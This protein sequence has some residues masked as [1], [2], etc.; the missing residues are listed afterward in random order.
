MKKTTTV[1]TL[2]LT[3]IAALSTGI[4]VAYARE[5]A[6]TKLAKSQKIEAPASGTTK[7]FGDWG[8]SCNDNPQ[9]Q[10][11]CKLAQELRQKSD[12]ARISMLEVKPEGQSKAAAGLTLP[13]GLDIRQGVSLQVDSGQIVRGINFSTCFQQ[14]C[15]VPMNFDAGTL[16]TL[17]NGKVLKITGKVLN[18]NN[19]TLNI[20]LQGFG[21][22]YDFMS[23]LTNTK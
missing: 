17:K 10:K 12:N 21:D 20:P 2:I 1:A 15:L 4:Y 9:G 13:F 23:K 22:A 3:T 18:G 7:Y 8:V 5:P 16:N 6:Q 14:G 19:I 11:V